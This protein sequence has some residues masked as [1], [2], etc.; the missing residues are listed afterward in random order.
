LLLPTILIFDFRI[1]TTVWIFFGFSFYFIY[2]ISM[3]VNE[4]TLL[5]C[6]RTLL[7]SDILIVFH[8]QNVAV[9]WVKHHLMTND[10]LQ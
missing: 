2:V 1:I 8:L 4:L 10:V 9:F 6:V 3:K 5:M 7:S